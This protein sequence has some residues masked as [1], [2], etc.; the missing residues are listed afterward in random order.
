[1]TRKRQGYIVEW[2][3]HDEYHWLNWSRADDALLYAM[4]LA[5]AG[6]G[7]IEIMH[8]ARG[9]VRPLLGIDVECP[10]IY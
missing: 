3:N 1:M 7:Y 4:M 6:H 10:N 5:E 8:I 2:D 9:V